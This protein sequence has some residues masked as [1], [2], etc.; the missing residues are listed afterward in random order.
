M[1]V[2]V[3]RH[4]YFF[5]GALTVWY[6]S[7]EENVHATHGCL[8]IRH[9]SQ[10]KMNEFEMAA[11]VVA[12]RHLFSSSPR[13]ER[14]LICL[15]FTIWRTPE[16]DTDPLQGSWKSRALFVVMPESIGKGHTV[17]LHQIEKWIDRDK[18]AFFLLLGGT[19]DCGVRL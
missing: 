15:C 4:Q 12:V 13:K 11:R 16:D 18:R 19:V 6:D 3:D 17:G 1:S 5:V 2:D 9:G 14:K 10:L 8:R 7:K